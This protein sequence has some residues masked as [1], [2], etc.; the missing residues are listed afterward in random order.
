METVLILLLM[1]V[2]LFYCIVGTAYVV[3][4]GKW[5]WRPDHFG[6]MWLAGYALAFITCTAFFG[7]GALWPFWIGTML[8]FGV[9]WVVL[10]WLDRRFAPRTWQ[11]QVRGSD[12]RVETR[13]IQHADGTRAI[14]NEPAA[15]YR[16]V[17]A[18]DKVEPIPP[19][20]RQRVADWLSKPLD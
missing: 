4:V 20:L 2:L 1:A 10:G 17:G 19:P 6:K 8:S 5:R 9:V 12:V 11:G 7:L 13:L 18:S 14:V 15:G 3:M 16:R